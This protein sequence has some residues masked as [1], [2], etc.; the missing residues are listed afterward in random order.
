MHKRGLCRHA[1]SVCL[2]VCVSVTFVHCVK[3][4]KHIK[5]FSPSGSHTILVFLYQTAWQ[6][7]DG[8]PPKGVECRWLKSRNQ[9]LSGLAVSNCCTVVCISHS[10]AHGVII[11]LII[12]P[13]CGRLFV[14]GGYWT[15]EAAVTSNKKLRLRYCTIEANYWLTRNIV[16]PLCDS[17]AT[18][19]LVLTDWYL[20]L[21]PITCCKE[22]F[23]WI[24][25]AS[26]LHVLNTFLTWFQVEC[27]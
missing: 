2:S 21:R 15:T 8:N 9:R 5:F 20:Y 25:K 17:R 3:T 24:Q 11:W 4:N 14:Y 13:C 1:V 16:R 10:V 22:N 19:C 23:C 18:C 27:L 6:Y 26:D 12:T 7:S